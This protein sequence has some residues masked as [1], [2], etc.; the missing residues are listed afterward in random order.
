MRP[1]TTC[2]TFRRDPKLI[3]GSVY[4]CIIYT[5]AE[6]QSLCCFPVNVEQPSCTV[7][8]CVPSLLPVHVWKSADK[9]VFRRRI[10]SS[11]SSSSS[12]SSPR[13][14]WVTPQCGGLPSVNV[15]FRIVFLCL[16]RKGIFYYVIGFL[17][18]TA[19]ERL[20]CGCSNTWN[21]INKSGGTG[22]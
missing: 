17:F 19:V 8:I 20:N 6:S 14:A 5:Q 4:P 10:T 2:I 18:S 15:L 21:V 1:T 11:I 9:W 3:Q 13:N 16:A 22:R 7:H 12:S